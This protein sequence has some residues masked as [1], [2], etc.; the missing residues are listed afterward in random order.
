M[1]KRGDC[2]RCVRPEQ[3]RNFIKLNHV[4]RVRHEHNG[5]VRLVGIDVDYLKDR[6]V[7]VNTFKGNK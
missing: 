2:V 7:K 3:S 6:F 5:C 1:F 4:Y